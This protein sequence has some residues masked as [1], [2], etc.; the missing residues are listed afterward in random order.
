M[1]LSGAGSA[2]EL[3]TTR[4]PDIRGGICEACGVVDPNQP[5]EV[6]YKLCKHYTGRDMRCSFCKESA[7][8]DEVIRMSTLVVKQDPYDP[9]SLVTLC[10]SYECTRKFEAKYHV[11]PR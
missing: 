10:G 5:S 7:D 6:Q 11:A 3:M 4:F 9:R 1:R 8:H 2:H